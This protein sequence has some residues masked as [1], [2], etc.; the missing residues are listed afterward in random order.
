MPSDL[1][2]AQSAQLKPITEIAEKL[3]LSDE[4]LD[5]YGKDKAKALF[6]GTA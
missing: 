4:D 3:G 5:L 1:E 2:I 6:G